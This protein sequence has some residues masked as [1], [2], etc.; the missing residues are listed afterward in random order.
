MP[1]Q[2]SQLNPQPVQGAGAD[3]SAATGNPVLVAGTDGTNAQTLAVNTDGGL[4]GAYRANITVTR[5][6]N[7]TPYG[8]GDVVGATAAAITF[9]L[10]GPTAGSVMVTSASLEIDVSAIPSGMTSFR[11]HLYNVTPPSAYADNAVWDLPSG[12]RA[13]YLGYIDLGSPADLGSTLFTQVDGV[14]KQL[15]LAA[16]E[17]AVYGYLVTTGAFTPAG[18]SEVY[19]VKL[20]TVA[21]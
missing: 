11:L 8:A 3:G 14:N 2:Q 13:S 19:V 17:T 6:A 15:K 5:P 4:T 18:N 12:D 9:T 16:A 10:S 7:T 20:H 21:L 1:S